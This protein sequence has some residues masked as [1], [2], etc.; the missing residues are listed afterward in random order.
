MHEA[1]GDVDQDDVSVP[2][3]DLRSHAAPVLDALSH[4]ASIERR[5][6]VDASNVI[7]DA[8]AHRDKRAHAHTNLHN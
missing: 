8:N 3:H 4:A 7:G 2:Q 5:Q 1:D 6:Q